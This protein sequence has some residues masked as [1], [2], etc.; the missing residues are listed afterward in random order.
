MMTT[1]FVSPLGAKIGRVLEVGEA[2]KDFKRVRM[3]FALG[4]SLK[5]EVTIKVRERGDMAF[6][7]KYE[8]VPHFCFICGRIGHAGKECPDEEL[9]EKGERFNIVLRA[10][11][12]KK[13]AGRFLSFHATTVPQAKR[14][15]NFSGEQRDQVVSHSSPSSMNANRQQGN[16]TQQIESSVFKRKSDAE[17]G[18][19]VKGANPNM[20]PT[21][22]EVLVK[23]VQ[24]LAVAPSPPLL[25]AVAASHMAGT[26]GEAQR[27]LELNSFNGS[28]DMSLGSRQSSLIS[29]QERLRLAKAMSGSPQQSF[30][31]PGATKDNLRAKRSRKVINP[32]V[33]GQS[34]RGFQQDER[35]LATSSKL[36]GD[37][38][39]T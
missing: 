3:D 19:L 17:E 10:S 16:A 6:L 35:P 22:A 36:S 25:K 34:F 20:M 38:V 1:Q 13:G 32:E 11:P 24:K 5:K 21:V 18:I 31:N 26:Y 15:L 9:E 14:G 30:R 12:C 33:L 8:N 29:I 7:V 28:S 4:D 23:G 27:V 2:V 39:Y 37:N